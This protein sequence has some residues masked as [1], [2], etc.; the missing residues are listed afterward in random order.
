LYPKKVI[1]SEKVDEGGGRL[2]WRRGRRRASRE[3]GGLGRRQERRL[4]VKARRRK[5]SWR[6][7]EG[8]GRRREARRKKG[9]W[10][11]RSV[12]TCV[13]RKITA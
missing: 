4:G 7:M 2:G 6:E 13:K 9:R 12:H 5:K 10:G 3:M 8:Q 11:R 1:L